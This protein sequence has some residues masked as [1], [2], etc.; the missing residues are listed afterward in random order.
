MYLS[1]FA[2]QV[3]LLIRRDNL[4]ETMSH[5]LIEQINQT[6]NID[7]RAGY[8]VAAARGEG[9]LEAIE[10]LHIESNESQWVNASAVFVFI[11]T[12][13][14]SNWLPASILKDDKGYVLTGNALQIHAD[15][16]TV[17]RHARNPMLLESSMPGVFA[18]GDI[19]SG[20]MNRVA[21]AV[22]EG[23]TAIKLVHEYLAGSA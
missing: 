11:S 9:R 10:L 13:P 22:G 2:Q 16:N 8:S 17:W 14:S 19:R 21:A 15:F 5:Y 20:S 3:S 12:R 6:P 18:A 7:V 4:R 23:S 1:R